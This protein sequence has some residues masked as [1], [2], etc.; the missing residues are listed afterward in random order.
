MEFVRFENVPEAKKTLGSRGSWGK[1]V[2]KI[3]Q[4]GQSKI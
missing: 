1:V 3:P 2:V 4:E